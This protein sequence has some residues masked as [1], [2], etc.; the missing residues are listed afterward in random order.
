M[1]DDAALNFPPIEDIEQMVADGKLDELHSQLERVHPADIAALLEE[2]ETETAVTV[3][4]LLPIEIAS[5]VLDETG[6]QIRQELVEKVDDERLADLLDELPMDDAVEFLE[7]LPDEV[8]DRL[9][10]LMEPEEAAEVQE[11]LG[12]EEE[13]AGRLM[14]RDV[15]ALRRQW[16][17][18]ETF[19]YL[20]SLEDAETL[21]YLYVV[22]RDNKLIGVVPLRTLI[23]S[24]PDATI[25]SIMSSDVVS[26][27]VAA[28]QEELA[29][30]VSRYDYFV[31]PVVNNNHELLGVVTV[32]DV[33]DIFEEEVTEDIQRLGGS[34]PL[35]QP[36]FAVSVFQI[37][38]KRI[39]WLLLLFVASTLSGEVIRMFQNELDIVV[40]LGFFITLITGTGGNAGSQTVATII[41]AITLD[42]VRLSNLTTAWRREVTVGLLLGLVMGAVG[43]VRALLWHTGFE[44]A[45]VVAL[46]L[47]LIVIW[48]T[49]VATV[50]PILADRFHI[51]PTVISGPMIA[52]IVDATGLMIYFS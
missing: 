52:T 11:L 43:I 16:T 44:V 12:Y 33:L 49:T 1:M 18:S 14:T 27:N 23:L 26:I 8:S 40:A 36:Y 46:T 34:E 29:E 37:V 41:R 24:Q 45:L 2:L 20:R 42:E 15:V 4:E 30:L 38:R 19:D 21:H 28:D 9:I 22:D 39:G 51:D 32:D 10:G 6:G 48:A 13:T 35:D 50:I 3:F 5:E 7:D 31:V 47:P 17:V 25:D